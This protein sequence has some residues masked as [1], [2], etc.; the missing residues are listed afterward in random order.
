MDALVFRAES[1]VWMVGNIMPSLA[2]LLLWSTVYRDRLTIA[3]YTLSMMIVYY[4]G[5]M[6]LETLFT[7]HCEEWL[8]RLIR[9]G[10]LSSFLLR[11]LSPIA[12]FMWTEIAW[13]VLR[14]LLLLVPLGLMAFRFLNYSSLPGLG[15][16]QI[17]VLLVALPFS[18]L[19]HFS[20]KFLLGSTTFWFIESQGLFNLFYITTSIF[21][22]SFL[23]LDL[24]PQLVVR[25]S[26]LLPFK[27]IYYFPLNVALGKLAGQDLWLGLMIQTGWLVFSGAT[28]LLVWRRGLKRYGAVGG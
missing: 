13:R 15:L 16:A 2:M 21:S 23:P 26:N 1:L 24:F 8:S 28:M 19:L 22:G 5:M 10:E 4:L 20:F 14:F 9:R 12:Y 6:V 7:P 18:Y 11:P 27:Y 25:I 17:A 3:G